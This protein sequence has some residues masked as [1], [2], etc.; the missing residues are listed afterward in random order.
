MLRLVRERETG[1][2]GIRRERERGGEEKVWSGGDEASRCTPAVWRRYERALTRACY[3][4]VHWGGTCRS[5][6]PVP[7]SDGLG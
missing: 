1:E 2:T 3:P 7:L 5:G 6:G 4:D